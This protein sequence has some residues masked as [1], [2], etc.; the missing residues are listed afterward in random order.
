MFPLCS[1]CAETM[2]QGTH[3]D[4]QRCMLRT[5]VVDKVRKTIEMVYGLVDVF[6]FSEYKLTRCDKGTNSEGLFAEHVNMF[7]KLKQE[8]S[9]YRSWVQSGEDEDRYIE[10]Y[11]R[12][13]GIFRTRQPF[14]KN[15]AKCV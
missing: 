12:A 1:A 7:L 8:S 10:D 3:S 14:P 6:E 11:R 2:N 4:E 15:R 13:E 9:G 5:W